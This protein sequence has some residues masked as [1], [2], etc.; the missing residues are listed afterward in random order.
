M[1]LE[2]VAAVVQGQLSNYDTDLF[3]PLLEAVGRRR[4]AR[5]TARTPADDVSLRVVAD[6]LRAMTFLIADGV[7]PGNEGRGYVLRKIMRRAMR[8]GKK[9]GIE[10][11]FL[12]ELTRDVVARMKAAY[13]ELV[14]PRGG[15]RRAW[16][17][18]R[19]SASGRPSSR[20]SPI[21]EEIAAAAFPQ[22]GT[23]PGAE[24][25][26]LYDTY[27][28]PARLHGGARPGPGPPGRRRG[29]RARA[30]SPSRSGR[31]SRARW[32]RSRATPST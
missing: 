31:G 17:R 21:F 26:R 9:L 10:G 11:A 15:G 4:A 12:S 13:P 22:G 6:H 30:R 16:S 32:A 1:G 20:P 23:V 24:V 5:P 19:R 7:L 3:T 18:S 27:G 2:R 25:F 29:L 28:L 14:V 8:H